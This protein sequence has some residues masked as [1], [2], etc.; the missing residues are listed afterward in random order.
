MQKR[1][2]YILIVL[3]LCLTSS[4]AFA[5]HSFTVNAPAVVAGGEVFSVSFTANSDLDNFQGP[6]ITGATVLAGPTQSYVRSTQIINGKRTS[7]KEITYNYVL[8]AGE[9]G[10]VMVGPARATIDG[11]VYSTKQHNIDIVK[12]EH[13]AAAQ[14]GSASA[15]PSG[16]DGG[17]EDVSYGKADVF[18]RLSLSKNKVVKGEPLVATLKIYTKN[19]IL[20][21]EDIHFPVF[22]G[23]WSQEIETPQNIAF[24]REKVGERIYSSA[25]LRKYMLIPQQSGSLSIDPAELVTVVQVMSRPRRSRSIFDDFFDSDMSTQVKKKLTTGRHTISV[26][27]LPANAPGSFGG[28]VGKLSMNVRITKDSVRSNEAAS[29]IVELSGSGNLN[30]VEAPQIAFPSDFEKYDVKTTNSFTYGP[31]GVSGKKVFEFPFIPRSEGEYV[32]PEISYSYYDTDKRQYVTLTNTPVKLKVAKGSAAHSTVYAPSAD[33][34]KVS[35]IDE[36]IRYISNTLPNLSR[37]G[38]FMVCGWLFYALAAF[39]VAVYFALSRLLQKSIALKGDIL[40]SRNKK[41]NKV[42]RSRLRLAAGFMEQNKVQEFYGELH[43]A[44]LGYVSDKLFMQFSDMQRDTIETALASHGAEENDI[45]DFISLLDD[46]EMVRYSPEGAAG[47]MDS[48]YKKAAR[49][50]SAFEVRL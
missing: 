13:S 7:S 44:L 33:K 42:V 12:G 20:G 34:R 3:I 48:Q 15:A 36:D 35:N 10:Q 45:K 50:I 30:L 19:N 9:S 16:Y 26:S 39:A 40:R 24:V 28:G 14:G 25:V 2:G 17:S 49:I 38:G 43:K 23:F 37:G 5:Q 31:D 22:N 1:V 6:A 47:A 4:G 41:A 32:I 21:F 29:L 46:C 27:D 11:T 8:Q 18:L